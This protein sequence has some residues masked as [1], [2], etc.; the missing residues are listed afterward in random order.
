MEDLAEKRLI[1]DIDLAPNVDAVYTGMCL[2]ANSE[3]MLLLNFDEAKGEF[4]G[5]TI[6]KNN[7]VEKYCTWNEDN[8]LELKN[9]NSKDLI[10]KIDLNKFL[11]IATSLKSLKSKLVSIF[12]YGNEDSF[13]LA[14]ILS[15]K[16]EC[17]ELHLLDEDSNWID[18]KVIKFSDINYIGFDTQY[19]RKYIKALLTI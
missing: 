18:I 16:N 3:I 7:D 11:D 17:V 8:Y 12:T 19:E 10:A 9:D 2:I 6:V 4:D 5:F 15:V 13:Y 1:I 14:K